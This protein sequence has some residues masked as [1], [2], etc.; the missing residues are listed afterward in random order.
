[1]LL[2]C[3]V[4]IT[5][6]VYAFDSVLTLHYG[7]TTTS[8]IKKQMDCY[9]QYWLAK[10]NEVCVGYYQ[11]MLF[12]HATGFTVAESIMDSLTTDGLKVKKLIA[13]S[14]DGPNINKQ[15]GEQY[16]QQALQNVVSE[17]MV[18]TGHVTFI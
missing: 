2:L 4:T 3:S 6:S 11:S 12:G 18:D 16:N 13:L 7:K 14:N 17:G 10:K 9:L 15:Y 8:Q 5:N 1:M